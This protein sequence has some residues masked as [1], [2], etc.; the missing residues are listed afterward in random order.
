MSEFVVV[1]LIAPMP[2]VILEKGV[3]EVSVVFGVNLLVFHALFISKIL[4]IAIRIVVDVINQF[5]MML[6][7]VR[8]LFVLEG[9][10]VLIKYAVIIVKFAVVI[11]VVVRL[12][13]AVMV[14]AEKY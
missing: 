13:N 7:A 5:L 12:N 4:L 1:V 10:V 14:F 9:V 2:I 6:T 11:L 3:V 8:V